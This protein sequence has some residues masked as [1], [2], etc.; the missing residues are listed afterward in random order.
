MQENI[1]TVNPDGV[2]ATFELPSRIAPP[3]PGPAW[4]GSV[5]GTGIL[6]TLLELNHEHLSFGHTLSLLMMVIGWC[7][8]WV[9]M[10]GFGL[11][12]WKNPK[13]FIET[14]VNSKQTPMWGMVSMGFL[15]IGA[16]TSTAIPAHFPSLTTLAWSVDWVMWI[17]GTIIGILTALGFACMLMRTDCGDPTPVWG[18][19]I[20]PP[21]VS[22]TTGAA[23]VPH[24]SNITGGF[25][26]NVISAGCFFSAL[27]LG[28]AVFIVAYHHTWRRKP[29]PLAASAATWIP[30]GIVGQSTAAAQAMSIQ[31]K[32]MLLPELSHAVQQMANIYGYIVLTIGTPLFI[33]AFYM[34]VRGFVKRMP[35]TPGW[36]AMTFPVG[37]CCLGTYFLGHN[38][39]PWFTDIS[40]ALCLM[41]CCTWTIAFVGSAM[42]IFHH[43]HHIIPKSSP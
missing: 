36:W 27:A 3:P 13:H 18:L 16:T 34:T 26:I 35:F 33:W 28:I 10:I 38:A 4:F 14:I 11:R 39:Y 21:M 19:P 30:L 6:S 42:S 29:L 25:W 5:M 7:I 2:R 17:I 12:S 1:A 41:L 23:L 15:A 24:T 40:V 37:T 22:S 32:H 8:F 20:V 31:S 9:L 43:R